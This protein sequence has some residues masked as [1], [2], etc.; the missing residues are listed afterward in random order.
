MTEH[1]RQTSTPNIRCAAPP[2]DI[3]SLAEKAGFILEREGTI[4]PAETVED[5][6]WE[7][8]LYMHPKFEEGANRALGE[9]STR[10][11]LAFK[12][13]VKSALEAVDGQGY[14]TMDVWWAIMKKP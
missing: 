1:Q 9:V 14:R 8:K 5:G 12:P 10:K 11:V 13:Q 7:V 2:T 4:I 6:S 3:K